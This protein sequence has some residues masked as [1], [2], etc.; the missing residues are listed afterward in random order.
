MTLVDDHGLNG[1][2]AKAEAP[3]IARRPDGRSARRRLAALVP[4]A[5]AAAAIA[6]LATV[7]GG[8]VPLA[9]PRCSP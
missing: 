7:L 1:A 3:A 4:G 9:G 2:A 6:A 8:L 5:A